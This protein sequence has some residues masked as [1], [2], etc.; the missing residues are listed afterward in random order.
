MLEKTLEQIRNMEQEA[1]ELTEKARAEAELKI[2]KFRD[3]KENQWSKLQIS[4]VKIQQ[5]IIEDY[6]KQ[7]QKEKEKINEKKM[8]KLKKI[9]TLNLKKNTI[10]DKIVKDMLC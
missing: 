1:R 3:E 2:K 5:E 4:M 10:I 6:R 8:D 7:A 9:E